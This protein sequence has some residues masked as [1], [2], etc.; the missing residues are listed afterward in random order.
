ML[1]GL[2]GLLENLYGLAGGLGCLGG[3]CPCFELTHAEVEVGD[4]EDEQVFD[5]GRVGLELNLWHL[6]HLFHELAFDAVESA[7][8]RD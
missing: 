5:K 1:E 4:E 7:F 6:V 8:C 3:L 2:T